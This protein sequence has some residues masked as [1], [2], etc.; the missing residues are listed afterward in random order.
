MQ[1]RLGYI[2]NW[3]CNS[4]EEGRKAMM[5]DFEITDTDLEG[6]EIIIASYTYQSYDGTA[7]ILFRKNGKLFE[8]NGS[9]CSCHGL[10][11][12]WEP[13]ETTVDALRKA[14][15][16]YRQSQGIEIIFPLILDMLEKGE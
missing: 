8:V 1:L 12:Q 6:C 16:Y 7:F 11:G 3:R 4:D 13:E 2:N 14:N 9:H 15:P 10:E 5:K